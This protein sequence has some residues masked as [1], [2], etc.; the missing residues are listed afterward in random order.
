MASSSSSSSSYFNSNRVHFWHYVL[1]SGGEP[2]ENAEIRLYLNDNPTTEANIFVNELSA[3][4]TTCSQADIKTNSNGYFEFWLGGE[5]DDGYSHTQEFR[6]EWY[7]A[8]IKPGFINNINPW[9][10]AFSWKNLNTGVDRNHKNKFVSDDMVSDWLNHVTAIVPSASPHDLQAVQFSTCGDNIYNKVVSNK[11]LYDINQLGLISSAA[12]L[13]SGGVLEHQQDITSW[14]VSG[15]YYYADITH[16]INITSRNV[17]I[18]LS[19]LSSDELYLPERIFNIDGTTTRIITNDN[20]NLRLN[21]QGANS[22][23]S[24]SSSSKSSSS[25]SL[26]GVARITEDGIRR[27]LTNDLIRILEY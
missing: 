19:I 6:L 22:S 3:V 4:S 1:N 16:P 11:F 26:S 9:P 8:G 18:Q 5:F 24:S 15:A 25:S 27:V 13:P 20:I 7:K 2:I 14:T 17:S 21:L 10:N 23:S 12:S